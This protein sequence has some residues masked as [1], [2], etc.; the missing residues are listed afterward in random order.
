MTIYFDSSV[1]KIDKDGNQILSSTLDKGE[2]LANGQTYAD[3]NK[4]GISSGLHTE[5]ITTETMTVDET[6]TNTVLG[7]AEVET[8][9]SDKD[10]SGK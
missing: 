7:E 3:V 6:K 4:N 1:V 9:V 2:K 5:T 8:E 10:S